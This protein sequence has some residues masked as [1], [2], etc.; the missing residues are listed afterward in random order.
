M[1][2]LAKKED[3]PE[4]ALKAFLS[5]VDKEEKKGDWYVFVASP[6]SFDCDKRVHEGGSKR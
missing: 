3:N 4:D 5:I 6:V 2:P 1:R